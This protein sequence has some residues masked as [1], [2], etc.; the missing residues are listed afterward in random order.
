MLQN[1][2][3]PQEVTASYE[4]NDNHIAQEYREL[5]TFKTFP[6]LHT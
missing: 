2:N 6:V 4:Q 5:K 1:N 3:T